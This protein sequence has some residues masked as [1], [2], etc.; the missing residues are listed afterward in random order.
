MNASMGDIAGSVAIARPEV[1]RQER[2]LQPEIRRSPKSDSVGKMR[3]I[4]NF[5]EKTATYDARATFPTLRLFQVTRHVPEYKPFGDLAEPR[6]ENAGT[7]LLG[8]YS[9]MP[10]SS[11]ASVQINALV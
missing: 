1:I 11:D 9:R 8:A 3:R 6:A 10:A 4:V 2:P 7:I 5:S